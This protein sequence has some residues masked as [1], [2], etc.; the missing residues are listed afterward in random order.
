MK[1]K[2]IF[3]LI[4]FLLP[5][6]SWGQNCYDYPC[7]IL[8]VKAAL[9]A[10]NYQ[11]AFD[12]LES[13]AAY[14]ESQAE[15][16][17]D[18]RQQ[19][20]NSIQQ[21][22]EQAQSERQRAEQAENQVRN[23]LKIVQEERDRSDALRE[24]A[25]KNSKINRL[26]AQALEIQAEDPGLA[27][28]LAH[29][30]FQLSGRQH[31]L[32]AKIR[33]NI[34]EDPT[35]L[36][37]KTALVGHQESVTAL[38]F[39]PDG[40]YIATG[41]RDQTAILWDL[42]GRILQHFVGHTGN[43]TQVAFT[44]DGQYLVTGSVDNTLKIWNLQGEVQ[45]TYS[46]HSG[47]ISNITF[48]SDGS[49]LL[50]QGRD[51]LKLWRK[52]GRLLAERFENNNSRLEAISFMDENRKIAGVNTYG[53]I[54]VWD[55]EGKL[56]NEAN[57]EIDNLLIAAFS[58]DG[59]RLLVNSIGRK[60][61]L[62]QTAGNTL[63]RMLPDHSMFR[64]AGFSA[65][66]DHILIA[67]SEGEV[68]AWEL[69]GRKQG[70][71]LDLGSRHSITSGAFSPDGQW[72]VAVGASGPPKLWRLS[73]GDRLRLGGHQDEI[74]AMVTAPDGSQIITGSNEGEI[75][76]WSANGEKRW[77]ANCYAGGVKSL[78]MAPGGKRFAVGSEGGQIEIRTDRGVLFQTIQGPAYRMGEIWALAFSPDGR[79]LFLSGY[80]TH[81]EVVD[82]ETG[83]RRI[84]RRTES[85]VF[86]IAFSP[87]GKEVLLGG[88]DGIAR[89]HDLQGNLLTEHKGDSDRTVNTVLFSLDGRQVLAAKGAKVYI[90][91]LEGQLIDTLVGHKSDIIDLAISPDGR[92]LLT[93]S[94]DQT[95]KLW[96]SNGQLIKTLEWSGESLNAVGFLQ[97]CPD[98]ELQILTTGADQLAVIRKL[99]G[100][101]QTI[102]GGHQAEVRTLAFHPTGELMA[103]AG[104][105]HQI[106]LWHQ[107]GRLL[108]RIYGHER[109]VR[110]IDFSP[111]GEW[112]LSGSL[113][114]TAKLWDRNGRLE[115]TFSE[116]EYGVSKVR[117][118][119]DGQSFLTAA[120]S[121][122][123]RR[124]LEGN[125]LAK[126]NAPFNISGLDIS[127]DGTQLALS[128]GGG[129]ILFL[130]SDGKTMGTFQT[131]PNDIHYAV[132]FSPDGNSLL[133]G[134]N[135]GKVRLFNRKGELIRTYPGLSASV[136][137]VSFSPACGSCSYEAGQLIAAGGEN[138]V[139]LW[140]RQGQE[141]QRLVTGTAAVT[142]LQFAPDGKSLLA[143]REDQTATRF[144]NL[145]AYFN[146]T[147]GFL[148]GE[149][150]T[151]GVPFDY[152]TVDKPDLILD[153]GL[154]YRQ[155]IQYDRWEGSLE[156]IS[157][158]NLDTALQVMNVLVDRFGDGYRFYKA[159][160]LYNYARHHFRNGA[161]KE[162]I[163][164]YERVIAFHPASEWIKLELATTLLF[165]GHWEQAKTLYDQ[166]L[167][168]KWDQ[169]VSSYARTWDEAFYKYLRDAAKIVSPQDAEL[170]KKAEQY[171][172]EVMS[173]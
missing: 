140:D 49:L 89:R 65:V 123:K 36:L 158:R 154:M 42:N 112:L 74:T 41:S 114:H 56:L 70:T 131:N 103:T 145:E 27:A 105:D 143:G 15:E 104:K 125:L 150:R 48:S 144:E 44:P 19:L 94:Y 93:G 147:R 171:L 133:V 59:A 107:Q 138:G 71:S 109:D 40:Q 54:S 87:D 135:E 113:D 43:V 26:T 116:H 61:L 12:N 5:V 152:E 160:V 173:Q 95:A 117:F 1:L 99:N 96:S 148:Y 2:F 101:L 157:L 130:S 22:K 127:G 29:Y 168:K 132:A 63:E 47:T 46:G 69:S 169:T 60:T 34:Y 67:R 137:T 85:D 77:T 166:W 21:E 120:G 83:N 51:G 124:D 75:I 58:P 10:K 55:L 52:D 50:S 80:G 4:A 17:A 128:G 3:C 90:W 72:L 45:R 68:E 126:Y 25:E 33:R 136:Y 156:A 35:A 24:A 78:A 66:D 141:V 102:L 142:Q 100:E 118:F 64:V 153:Y 30:A 86:S 119:P 122:L 9:S 108:Q 98:C 165:A 76:A 111:D 20:F 139:M 84:F 31:P 167:G 97:A 39:S 92:Y 11:S 8:K 28:R 155:A 53:T 121:A 62:W 18:L 91:D 106:L 146:E 81:V 37:L 110:S 162:A 23:T 170:L 14:P 57:M 134:S 38:A 79:Q 149:S 164:A 151:Y 13:A 16:I 32:A 163:A 115:R 129:Q 161:F 88:M 159:E 73:R 172:L 82:L 6:W 7:V